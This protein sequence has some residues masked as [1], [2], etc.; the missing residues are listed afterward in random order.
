MSKNVFREIDELI[1]NKKKTNIYTKA[2]IKNFYLTDQYITTK[3]DNYRNK[4]YFI[5]KL[6][7]N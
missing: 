2:I 3:I 6:N 4:I 1:K 5:S 7:Y